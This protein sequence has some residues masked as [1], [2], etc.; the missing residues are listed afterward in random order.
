VA[1]KQALLSAEGGEARFSTLLAHL[2]ASYEE[3]AGALDPHHRNLRL[4]GEPVRISVCGEELAAAM[5]PSFAHLP[6]AEAEPGSR[7]LKLCAWDLEAAGLQPIPAPW[8][9]EAPTGGEQLRLRVGGRVLGFDYRDGEAISAVEPDL[10]RGY[11]CAARAAAVGGHELG[12]PFVG[13]LRSMLATPQRCITHGAI[14]CRDGK[15]VLITAHGGSGKSTLAVACL[16]AGLDLV[17]DD[18]TIVEAGADPDAAAVA[19]SLHC[20]AKLDPGSMA[21][22]GDLERL[23]VGQSTP[24]ERGRKSIVDLRPLWAGQLCE[25]SELV[26]LVVPCFGERP[27]IRELAPSQALLALAPTS[28]MAFAGAEEQSMAVMARLARRLPAFELTVGP[29]DGANAALIEE[30]IDRVG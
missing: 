17:G 14:P 9:E 11:V 7:P 29:D 25:R 21:R 22:F 28:V 18:I 19:H 1:G 20:T 5:L 10:R 6:E 16:F 12:A 24:G 23:V 8:R 2:R 4:G 26:A 27:A 15:G 13:A 30:L 3:A